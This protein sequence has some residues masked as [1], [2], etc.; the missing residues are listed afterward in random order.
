MADAQ[1]ER[2]MVQDSRSPSMASVWHCIR[3]SL[4]ILSGVF[5]SLRLEGGRNDRVGEQM[6]SGVSKEA[7]RSSDPR[8]ATSRRWDSADGGI[9]EFRERLQCRS[10]QAWARSAIGLG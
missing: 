5:K 3:P 4:A 2:H 10:R 7:Q 6:E 1:R 9:C 8:A